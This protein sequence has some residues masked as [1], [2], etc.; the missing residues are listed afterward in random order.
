MAK[1]FT[2][3]R[4]LIEHLASAVAGGFAI[5]SA[6]CAFVV[7]SAKDPLWTWLAYG[8]TVGFLVVA[9][10]AALFLREERVSLVL[11]STG[12]PV[13]N[14]VAIVPEWGVGFLFFL[15]GS[16]AVFGVYLA[17]L[18]HNSFG[19]VF[20]DHSEVEYPTVVW[21]DGKDCFVGS[22]GE[23][24]GEKPFFLSNAFYLRV[25][26]QKAR[27]Y[28]S[29]TLE[30]VLVRVDEPVVFPSEMPKMFPQVMPLREDNLYVVLIDSGL[31]ASSKRFPCEHFFEREPE[32]GYSSNR[33]AA[34]ILS[35]DSPEAL[36][37]RFDAKTPGLYRF[38]ITL[39]VRTPLGREE[40]AGPPCSVF[41]P[42]FD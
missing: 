2:S 11:D 38:T 10:V 27:R 16:T 22:L 28:E 5:V 17:R 23:T 3:V 7:Q 15:L 21:L 40:I 36:L 39:D 13:R 25:W 6:V 14:R 32:G 19:A 29:V 24:I 30:R 4:Q 12:S 41:F 9:I 8:C 1:S 34:R 31:G 42:K 37:I 33:L 20:V 35:S 26:I 18:P